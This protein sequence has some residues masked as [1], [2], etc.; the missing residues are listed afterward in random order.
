[1]EG[2]IYVTRRAPAP[3]A[4]H[5]ADT[6]P[7]SAR[8]HRTK[9]RGQGRGSTHLVEEV[10]GDDELAPWGTQH[11]PEPSPQTQCL[12]IHN[13]AHLVEEVEGDE[14]LARRRGPEDGVGAELVL[15][16]RLGA[17]LQRREVALGGG[18]GR[19]GG[20]RCQCPASAV[21]AEL[22]CSRKAATHTNCTHTSADTHKH[23]YAR[24][25]ANNK[26]TKPISCDN[27]L[28]PM[29][30]FWMNISYF[31]GLLMLPTTAERF[32]GLEPVL[33]PLTTTLIWGARRAVRRAGCTALAQG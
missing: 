4:S 32:M 18:A 23:S 9:S 12:H 5:T 22:A 14:E 24:S 19:R 8:M 17:R 25:Y 10:E 30:K 33:R 16:G 29:V 27:K 2:G 3:G 7:P 20:G 31:S 13:A 6:T 11:R 26:L 28:T 21:C 1:M 15:D